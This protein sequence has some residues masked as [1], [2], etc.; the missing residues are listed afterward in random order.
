MPVS[1]TQ[2]LAAA[3]TALDQ[4]RLAY[5]EADEQYIT[6]LNVQHGVHKASLC[7]SSKGAIQS[8]RRLAH[9]HRLSLWC[10]FHGERK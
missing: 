5:A 6:K 10:R 9:G 2:V 8:Y 7:I 3:K 1:D 4:Q